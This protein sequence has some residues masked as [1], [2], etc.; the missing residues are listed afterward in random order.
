MHIDDTTHEHGGTAK[1]YTYS[2]DYDI[3]GKS[4]SWTAEVRQS[5][6]DET[7]ELSGS[8]PLTSPGVVAVAEQVVRDAVM[9]QIDALGVTA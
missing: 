7:H 1:V 9:A 2:A 3:D 6:A 4:I 8:I 5:G